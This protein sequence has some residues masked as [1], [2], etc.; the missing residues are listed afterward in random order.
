MLKSRFR[1]YLKSERNYSPHTLS[2]YLSDLDTFHHFLE[3]Y[4]EMDGFA[5][6][7]LKDIDHRM[8]RNWMGELLESGLSRR[9]VARKIASLNTWFKFLQKSS[10]LES[11]P[12]AKI[13]VPKFEKKLPAFLKE[14]NAEILFNEVEW[15]D[16]FEGIRGKC[17]LE[18]LYGCG[19]RRSELIDLQYGN[20]EFSQKTF[21]VM[22]KGNKE[23]VVPFGEHVL[24]A[25]EE[26]MQ[27]CDREGINYRGHFFVK[28]KG[29]K[30]YPKLVY[31]I[32]NHALDGVCTLSKKSPHVLRHTFA[33]HLLNAGADLNAIKEL[34]GHNSLAA[35]QVY[36]HN[37]IKKL[38]NIYKKSHPKA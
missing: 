22:G 32:V 21:K 8:I 4:Y 27:V 35:T 10:T 15:P 38:K 17:I 33:T 26:Y 3:E 6:A 23:R 37:S 7:D 29:E 5:E 12:A 13:K 1:N 30:L 14:K 24:Q 31:K 18:V 9:S 11:N 36:V 25:M 19:L 28:N 2:A 20:I 16:T 34:L